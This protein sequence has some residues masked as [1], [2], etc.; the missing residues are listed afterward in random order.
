[1]KKRNRSLD[2]LRCVAVLLVIGRHLWVCPQQT[3][4]ILNKV[5][6]LIC[7]VGWIGVDI[8]F[9]LSGFLISGLLFSDHRAN[10]RISIKRF[11][12]RRGFKIYPPFLALLAITSAVLIWGFWQIR[13]KV[14]NPEMFWDV[15]Q[16]WLWP[17]LLFV[18]NYIDPPTFNEQLVWSINLT[19]SLA[20]EEHFYLLLPLILAV[21][22]KRQSLRN[23]PYMGVTFILL[24]LVLRLGTSGNFT[25][26]QNLMPT[27]IRFDSLFFGV[28]LSYWRHFHLESFF[29]FSQHWPKLLPFGIA[30]LSP[31]VFWEL[32]QSRFLYTWGYTLISVGTGAILIAMLGGDL[33]RGLPSRV[34]AFI[35][36]RSYSIYLF[37]PAAAW[38]ACRNFNPTQNFD[39]WLTWACCYF[40]LSIGFGVGMFYI[41]ESP[42]LKLRDALF[43]DL[44]KKH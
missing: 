7:Q 34:M 4:V 39:S 30:C 40:V 16:K 8:F 14:S 19:W 37:H 35:G 23:I 26:Q 41:V 18:Q 6:A 31:V 20:I 11:Y 33:G 10:G 13:D 21:M 28:V 42:M 9:V 12:I 15:F 22:A 17:N 3:S 1:M 5:T 24:C 27:H 2:V 29:K 44:T 43:P 36:A 32:S 38:F 25:T